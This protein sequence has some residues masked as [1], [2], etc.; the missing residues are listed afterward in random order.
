MWMP[1]EIA[2]TSHYFS[3]HGPLCILHCVCL[4]CLGQCIWITCERPNS[5]WFYG[6]NSSGPLWASQ[7][8]YSNPSE[9]GSSS[10]WITT[11]LSDAICRPLRFSWTH[12]QK[13]GGLKVTARGKK[14]DK[15]AKAKHVS[16]SPLCF[17]HFRVE[18]LQ[19]FSRVWGCGDLWESWM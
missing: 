14:W 6:S 9:A 1:Q 15:E 3:V 12:N 4:Q 13:G 19:L 17:F 2:V 11:I 7:L 5:L 10:S 8:F 18:I 16:S